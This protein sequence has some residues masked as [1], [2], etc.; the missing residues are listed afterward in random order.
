M[1]L[2][3]LEYEE[4]G[5]Y[6]TGSRMMFNRSDGTFSKNPVTLFEILEK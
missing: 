3:D 4:L 6:L 2:K 5:M 1:T